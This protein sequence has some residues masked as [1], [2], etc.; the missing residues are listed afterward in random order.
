MKEVSKD[1]YK[2]F[3][4]EFKITDDALIQYGLDN[5]LF[6]PMDKVEEYWNKLKG[7]IEGANK[8]IF[9]RGYGRD[10]KG[11]QKFIDFYSNVFNNNMIQ[12]DP[13]N[14]AVPTKLIRD[15][16]RY[17]KT[18]IS[19]KST[20]KYIQNY[21]ISHIFGKTKN[22]Y[23]FTAPWNIVYMPKI[24][25]PLTGHESRGDFKKKFQKEFQKYCFKK[26][27]KYIDEYNEIVSNDVFLTNKRT[28]LDTLDD[29][30]KSIQKFKEMIENEFSPIEEEK[31]G[32]Y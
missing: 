8:I 22:I 6:I 27:E 28:Y 25:D 24:L 26:F 23:T 12:K 2:L 32:T 13:T 9:I 5:T 7:E 16:T 4:K 14:N 11:T 29:N 21:Q 17:S 3:M 15:L 1:A 30:D 19:N 18:K 31:L 10:A 20:F